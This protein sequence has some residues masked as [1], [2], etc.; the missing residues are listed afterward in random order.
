MITLF[1]IF[2][3]CVAFF[4]F[5]RAT[6]LGRWIAAIGFILGWALGSSA[7]LAHSGSATNASFLFG[8]IGMIMG[9]ALFPKRFSAANRNEV[10]A[11][12]RGRSSEYHPG[13]ESERKTSSATNRA[14]KRIDGD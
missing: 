10:E 1:L 14:I 2:T 5:F 11:V 4:L 13:G 7:G 3:T 6:T 12:D 8:A 9:A